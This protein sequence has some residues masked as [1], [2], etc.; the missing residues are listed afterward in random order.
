MERLP[1]PPVRGYSISCAIDAGNGGGTVFSAT[2]LGQV[3]PTAA[4]KF[5]TNNREVRTLTALQGGSDAG[6]LGICLGAPLL[7]DSGKYIGKPFLVTE[8]LGQPLSELFA[9]LWRRPIEERWRTM[10]VLGRLLLRRLKAIH[11]RGFVHCDMNP[12]NVLIGRKGHDDV[13]ERSR[14]FIIDFGLAHPFP[15]GDPIKAH[16]GTI[17]YNSIRSTDGGP[18]GPRDDLEALGWM[19]CHGVLGVLPWMQWRQIDWK[20]K[21]RRA[22]FCKRVQKAKVGLLTIGRAESFEQHLYGLPAAMA[23]Y[24]RFCH[25]LGG[26]GS[27]PSSDYEALE[28]LLGGQG[29]PEMQEEYEDLA[30]FGEALEAF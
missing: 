24:M 29:R 15:G 26:E 11:G 7:L 2:R 23:E 6:G 13:F 22:A 16:A 12:D 17:E 5:P 1:P 10:S 9:L 3:A 30:I 21:P 27:V 25:R 4:V 19:L 20:D 14:P 8:L 18:R 28:R